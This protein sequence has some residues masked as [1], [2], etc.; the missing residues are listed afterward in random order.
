M[1]VNDDEN[2]LTLSPA[3]YTANKFFGTWSKV[4]TM[5][6][7]LFNEAREKYTN[8]HAAEIKAQLEV[9]TIPVCFDHCVTDVQSGLTSTEKNCIRDCFFKKVSSKDDLN[10]MVQ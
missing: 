5:Q 7:L 3:D 6:S 8:Q 10:M 4:M 1:L 2:P 9:E